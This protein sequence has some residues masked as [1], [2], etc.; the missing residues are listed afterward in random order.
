MPS[1]DRLNQVPRDCHVLIGYHVD[2]STLLFDM[3]VM[4]AEHSR[5]ENA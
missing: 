1:S 5:S 2:Q 4:V 3:E